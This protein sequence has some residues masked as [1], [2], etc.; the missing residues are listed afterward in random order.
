[1]SSITTS[2]LLTVVGL[3]VVLSPGLLLTLPPLSE[4]DVQKKGISFGGTKDTAGTVCT[5][6]SS[7]PICL[8]AKSVWA[9]M[10][11]GIFPV[12][13]HAVVFYLTLYMVQ[14]QFP[15]NGYLSMKSLV[16]LS[17]LFAVLSPGLL[18]TLP[19]LSKSD[20]GFNNQNVTATDG[21]TTRFYCNATAFDTG[22]LGA[23]CKKCTST[24]A[25]G[26]SSP[27]AIIVH[28]V[29]FGVLVYFLGSQ[30]LS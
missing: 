24:F 27:L 2:F 29:V 18:I 1:M 9:S 25:S 11:T 28:S 16:I 17:V 19:A 23:E 30:Y 5:P 12:L 10:Q 8:N 22:A 15:Q 13:V 26:F 6:G 4:T 3:F 7:N 21:A 14:K 20:C